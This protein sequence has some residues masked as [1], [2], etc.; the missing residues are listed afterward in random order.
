MASFKA[1]DKVRVI[2]RETTADDE[3]N[4][5]YYSYFGGLTGSVDTI[6]EDGSVCVDIDLE[7][8]SEA[9]RERHL[10]LQEAEKKRWLEGLSGE[11]R[12]R[13]T[14]EQKQLKLSYKILTSV[15][16]L[17]HNKGDKPTGGKRAAKPEVSSE[18]NGSADSK[19]EPAKNSEPR[20]APNSI[21]DNKDQTA[22]SEEASGSR[23][24]SAQDLEKAEE[25]YLKSIQSKQQ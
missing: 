6:Y 14:A 4:D 13:L 10:A 15:K 2:T 3:K 8:L 11:A 7:S 19:K 17:E 25:D 24:P 20:A 18:A 21:D 16:E 9:A 23:R 22:A 12:G 5:L 1:G